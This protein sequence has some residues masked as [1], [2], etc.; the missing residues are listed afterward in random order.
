MQGT[1]VSQLLTRI[2]PFDSM[3]LNILS[4]GLFLWGDYEQRHLKTEYIMLLQ[5]AII[6]RMFTKKI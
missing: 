4:E 3:N 2:S 1:S 6:K 5:A